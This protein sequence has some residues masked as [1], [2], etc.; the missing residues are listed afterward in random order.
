MLEICHSFYKLNDIK[1]NP[2]KYEVIKIND[3]EKKDLII[4]DLTIKKMNSKEGNRFLGIFFTH[5]NNRLV[6]IKKMEDMIAGFVKIMTRK[7][8]TDKQVCKLW[9][10][11]MIPVLKYQLLGVVILKEEAKRLMALINTLIKHKYKLSK[12]L[13]NCIIYDKDLYG[14]KDLYSLQMKSLSKNLMYM[15]NGNEDLKLLFQIQMKQLQQQNWSPF[16]YSEIAE[17]VRFP[18]R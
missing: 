9:N 5:N 1:A 16:C 13:P 18:T 6:H 2:K 17:R 7:I 8:L 10:I 11:N 14:V 3:K 4:D 12:S 15:A